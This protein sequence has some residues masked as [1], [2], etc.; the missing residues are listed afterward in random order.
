MDYVSMCSMLEFRT[1]SM[2]E[3]DMMVEA[4]AETIF[5]LGHMSF[6]S[7]LTLHRNIEDNI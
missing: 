4:E 6:L 5:E 2:G 7:F 1:L 3:A